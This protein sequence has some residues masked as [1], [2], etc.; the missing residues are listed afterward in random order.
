MAMAGKNSG[1][2]TLKTE[3]LAPSRQ[4]SLMDGRQGGPQQQRR[5]IVTGRPSGLAVDALPHDL[6][7]GVH[8]DHGF[9]A[10]ASRTRDAVFIEQLR[11]GNSLSHISRCRP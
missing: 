5:L 9:I 1:D 2:G 6:E 7:F 4:S 8:D 3:G 11:N 10:S